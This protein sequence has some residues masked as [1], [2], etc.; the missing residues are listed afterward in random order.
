M[1]VLLFDTAYNLS[2]Y[3]VAL[4]IKRRCN[5]QIIRF[6]SSVAYR[7]YSP[8]CS[9]NCIKQITKTS[10]CS[11]TI[12]DIL[13]DDDL[14]IFHKMLESSEDQNAFISLANT[15]L[16]TLFMANQK[17][18]FTVFVMYSDA[19]IINFVGAAFAKLFNIKCIVQELGTKRPSSFR[20]EP[21]GVNARSIIHKI[22][23]ANKFTSDEMYNDKFVGNNRSVLHRLMFLIFL[24]ILNIE[25]LIFP[26]R[27]KYYHQTFDWSKY[28]KLAMFKRSRKLNHPI[29]RSSN[30]QRKKVAI[31]LQLEEDVNFKYYSDF[32]T[33]LEFLKVALELVLSIDAEASVNPH[34]LDVSTYQIYEKDMNKFTFDD[35]DIILTINSTVG[36]EFFDTVPVITF[37]RSFYEN[38]TFK[39]SDIYDIEAGIGVKERLQNAKN[40]KSY[41]EASHLMSDTRF[42]ASRK[43]IKKV[44]D[45]FIEA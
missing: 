45:R 20:F 31:A 10:L 14:V 43:N 38:F 41:Y 7:L 6:Q 22:Y 30:E 37:G 35:A 17:Y 32:S 1:T 27:K 28:F 4:E 8:W 16:H 21:V 3:Q 24:F 44:V 29:L 40:F 25:K 42:L 23:V 13:D 15:V 36:F 11:K 5:T 39:P 12:F 2:T 26:S 9:H 18:Q 33:N 34:P 19:R